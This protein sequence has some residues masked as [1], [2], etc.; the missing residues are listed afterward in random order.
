MALEQLDLFSYVLAPE[1]ICTAPPAPEPPRSTVNQL[2]IAHY[3]RK[4]DLYLTMMVQLATPR[5]AIASTNLDDDQTLVEPKR[6]LP[7]HVRRYEIN[8]LAAMR[9]QAIAQIKELTQ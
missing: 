4:A 6:P 2:A 8:R 5:P 7:D 3:Q 9:E 1:E